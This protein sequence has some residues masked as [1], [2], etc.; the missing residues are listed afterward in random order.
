[1]TDMGKSLFLINEEFQEVKNTSS[2]TYAKQFHLG[3]YRYSNRQDELCELCEEYMALASIQQEEIKEQEFPLTEYMFITINP[4]EDTTLTHLHKSV[5][6]FLRLKPVQGY[7][8]V[9]EQ[10]GTN[11][12]E[13][14]KGFHTHMIIR[15]NWLK[16]SHFKRDIQR[17][18]KDITNIKHYRCLNIATISDR[19]DLLKRTEYILGNKTDLPG[20]PKRQK[21]LQDII[22]RK[23]NDLKHFEQNNSDEIITEWQQKDKTTL[24]K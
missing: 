12:E 14:G 11:E 20:N 18:F 2:E 17:V 8:Q 1:M 15:Q 6:A 10:R 13:C 19:N 22:F 7:I 5:R 21:Q 4:Y 24:K 3:M 23:R 16:K 9:T